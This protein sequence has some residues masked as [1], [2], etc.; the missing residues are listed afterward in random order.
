VAGRGRR[1]PQL[2]LPTA[3]PS[4]RRVDG[5]ELHPAGRERLGGERPTQ[6]RC[7]RAIQIW[8]KLNSTV[9][10]Q[11]FQADGRLMRS[12]PRSTK[13]DPNRWG[14]LTG[15]A[16]PS[17]NYG[18]WPAGRRGRK[19]A[20]GDFPENVMILKSCGDPDGGLFPSAPF[21]GTSPVRIGGRQRRTVMFKLQF[22]LGHGVG[23]IFD[24]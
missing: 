2:G 4:H 18:G 24:S 17:R 21:G 3:V 6:R 7:R 5:G 14:A 22:R 16:L 15:V 20:T 11:P 9:R 12:T 10:R 1:P 13:L 8:L 23:G 19:A